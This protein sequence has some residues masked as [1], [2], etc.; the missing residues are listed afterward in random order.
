M[1]LLFSNIITALLLFLAGLWLKN[2]LP[3]YFNEKG[4]LLAQKEDIEEITKKIEKVKKDFSDDTEL[5]K[6]GLQRLI[7]LETS[8]RNEERNSIIEFYSKYN[9]WLYA[10]LEINYGTYNRQNIKDLI[11]KRIYIE[12]FYGETGI[13]QS[14]VKLLVK[15]EEIISLSSKL[16][17]A[18]LEYKGWMDTRLLLLQQNIES[19]VYLSDEFM[20]LFKKFDENKTKL[21]RLAEDDREL[22][23][24]F[25]ELINTFYAAKVTE[26]KKI[27]PI[28][29]E[30]TDKV[31]IY[32]TQ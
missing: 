6:S 3:S 8:H 22:R 23:K 27:I 29:H 28:D 9:Q 14:K 16:W 12:K 21:E 11:E 24:V 31:K 30:F 15:D 25:R 17:L 2:Y 18:L 1:D 26:Y 19:Q 7:N 4:K 10:L 32:L 13:A 20:P 5:L